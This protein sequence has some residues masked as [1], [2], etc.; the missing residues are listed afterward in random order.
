MINFIHCYHRYFLVFCS[1]I[2]LLG[3][4]VM[5]D[6]RFKAPTSLETRYLVVISDLHMGLGK[7]NGE[8]HPYEDFRWPGAL[9][10]FLHKISE[11]GNEHVDLVIAG[12]FLELWQYPADV[13]CQGDGPNLGCTINEV[14]R[15]AQ[16]VVKA[17]SGTSDG[18]PKAF[19]SLA[20]F[21]QRG[22]NRL[23]I[24]PGNHDAA[25]LVPQVWA[26]V[27]NALQADRGRI[28]LVGKDSLG[29]WNSIDGRVVI[30]HGQQMGA[31]LNRYDNWPEVVPKSGERMV[32]VEGE[33]NVQKLFNSVEREYPIID[34][35]SPEVAGAWYRA[36]DRGISGSIADIAKLAYFM[37]F[38]TSFE[39]KVD[40]LGGGPTLQNGSIQWDLQ[41]ARNEL[42]YKLFVFSLPSDDKLRKLLTE[43]SNSD[44]AKKIVA[45]FNALIQQLSDDELK[46]L[47]DQLAL[48][49]DKA[50]CWAPK[51]GAVLEA[52]V[53]SR[54]R[55]KRNH[56]KLRKKTYPKMNTFIYGHTHQ[57]EQ[58]HDIKL[59]DFEVVTVF[60]S[61]AFQ[62]VMDDENYRRRLKLAYPQV[63]T[64]EGLKELDLNKDFR[65]CYT[66][67]LGKLEGNKYNLRTKRWYMAEHEKGKFIDVGSPLCN[68]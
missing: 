22:E 7:I 10:A 25:I 30:E 29:V 1:W 66:A 38:E 18:I 41:Y 5:A 65:P 68:W 31:D 55:I 39:H 12:D 47:C 2:F 48:Q 44:L 36:Q 61:G 3:T 34:N 64:S 63:S 40:V 14:E 42:G 62:R 13:A 17:H 19:D 26:I 49:A 11:L 54:H 56:L 59:S 24:V 37:L 28:R 35:L 60:N 45:E 43:E 50:R 15:I 53:K 16:R 32:R 58:G 51:G 21:S 20:A 52:L 57:L 9:N 67:V 6:S 27:A 46:H 4:E 33:L 8:W 23:H